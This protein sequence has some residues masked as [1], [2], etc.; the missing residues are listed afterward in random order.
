[1]G[2][3]Q[4]KRIYKRNMGEEPIF[5]YGMYEDGGKV[6]CVRYQPYNDSYI[7][8]LLYDYSLTEG[9]E[10][11]SDGTW[12]VENTQQKNGATGMPHKILTLANNMGNKATWVSGIG[13]TKA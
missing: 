12:K 1:M 5:M 9:E 4:C 11:K 3:Y 10:F 8:T 7:S 13:G 2:G 6:Y